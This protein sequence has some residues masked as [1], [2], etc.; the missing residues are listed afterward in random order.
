MVWGGVLSRNNQRLHLYERAVYYSRRETGPPITKEYT[1]RQHAWKR[2]ESTA[3]KHEN[4]NHEYFNMGRATSTSDSVSRQHR[5]EIG[6]PRTTNEYT[7]LEDPWKRSIL[8]RL[9]TLAKIELENERHIGATGATLGRQGIHKRSVATTRY[10]RCISPTM[11]SDMKL[12]KGRPC[13]L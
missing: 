4:D 11:Y 1:A 2:S 9:H 7:A 12:L 6:P 10:V 13:M 5:Q 8:P 3:N